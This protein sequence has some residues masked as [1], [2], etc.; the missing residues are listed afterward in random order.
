M[1]SLVLSE[2]LKGWVNAGP[3]YV[4]LVDEYDSKALGKE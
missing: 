3:E 1:K 4:A 2:G